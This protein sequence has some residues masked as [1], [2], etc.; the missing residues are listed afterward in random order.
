MNAQLNI[1]L[2]QSVDPVEIACIL[3]LVVRAEIQGLTID[4]MAAAQ[5]ENGTWIN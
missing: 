4:E 1:Q 5:D 3:T 2:Q